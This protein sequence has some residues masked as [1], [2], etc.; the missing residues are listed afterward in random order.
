MDSWYFCHFW[1]YDFR[2]FSHSTDFLRFDIIL[3]SDFIQLIIALIGGALL[4]YMGLDMIICAVKNKVKIDINQEQANNGNM[5]LSGFLLSAINPCFLI[6]WA[7]I[8]LG[9]LLEAYKAYGTR[10]VILFYIGHVSTDF[11]W[12]GF[13]GLLI[14]TTKKSLT[15]KP[16]SGYHRST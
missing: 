2:N 5:I 14:G 13:I 7:I 9:F 10:G 3:Q 11:I 4:I 16:L 15:K 6:W 12:Y 1:A 8:G